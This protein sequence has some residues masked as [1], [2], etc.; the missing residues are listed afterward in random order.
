M[1]THSL[2]D[3]GGQDTRRWQLTWDDQAITLADPD[4]QFV[5]TSPTISFG[6][7]QE[8][9][10]FLIR[11]R[12]RYARGKHRVLFE[13]N[14]QAVEDLSA[15]VEPLFAAHALYRKGVSLLSLPC[16]TAFGLALAAGVALLHGLS[17][18]GKPQGVFMLSLAVVAAALAGRTS[19][20]VWRRWSRA[21]QVRHKLGDLEVLVA[22]LPPTIDEVICPCRPINYTQPRTGSPAAG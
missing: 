20:L 22:K 4:G 12:I 13:P 18:A 6:M 1:P 2:I 8:P 7:M 21:R 19:L 5:W 15:H 10:E 17:N 16:F 11:S 14:R 9:F 3:P